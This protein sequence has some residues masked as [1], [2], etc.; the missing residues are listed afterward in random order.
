MSS[1]FIK[2]KTG[3]KCGC[4]GLSDSKGCGCSGLGSVSMTVQ[5]QIEEQLKAENV[6][7]D[8]VKTAE[9]YSNPEIPLPLKLTGIAIIIFII[10]QNN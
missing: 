5:E 3:C 6:S 7:K 10:T 8:A 1:G 4:N 9:Q 2:Q